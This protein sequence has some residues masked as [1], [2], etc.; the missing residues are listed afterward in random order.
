M[1]SDYFV[2]LRLYALYWLFNGLRENPK[3][4][5]SVNMEVKESWG[6]KLTGIIIYRIK[7]KNCVFSW[8]TF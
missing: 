3:I 5:M 4:N 6:E 8:E 1:F 7:D 2:I